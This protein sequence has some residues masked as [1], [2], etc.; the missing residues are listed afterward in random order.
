MLDLSL[1]LPALVGDGLASFLFQ[2][3]CFDARGAGGSFDPLVNSSGVA[4]VGN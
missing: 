4:A 1:Q 2:R 3:G